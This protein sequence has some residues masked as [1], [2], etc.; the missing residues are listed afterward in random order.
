M[1]KEVEIVSGGGW[2]LTGI[3]HGDWREDRERGGGRGGKLRKR[4]VRLCAVH[5]V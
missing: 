4:C 1:V 3:R 2:G 5:E